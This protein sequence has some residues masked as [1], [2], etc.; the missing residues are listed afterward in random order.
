VQR[1][2]CLI[3]VHFVLTGGA[4]CDTIVVSGSLMCIVKYFGNSLALFS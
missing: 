4:L 1:K 3:F 2:Y